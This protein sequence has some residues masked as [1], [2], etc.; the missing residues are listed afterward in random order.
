MNLFGS[1]ALMF[2]TVIAPITSYQLFC[3]QIDKSYLQLH[4][5][6]S[7]KHGNNIIS[8]LDVARVRI[9]GFRW[10][11]PGDF[12]VHK[13]Y[14]LVL[15]FRNRLSI[16]NHQNKILSNFRVG[17]YLGIRLVDLT[18]AKNVNTIQPMLA[19]QYCDGEICWFQRLVEKEL[20]FY[21]SQDAGAQ[22]LSSIINRK[23]WK[24]IR[25]EAQQMGK[26]MAINLV[27]ITVI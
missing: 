24:N 25:G 12:V 21:R 20:W 13:E 15:L 27:K 26:N 23:Q 18:P 2:Y 8:S 3:H 16:I 19:I 17:L 5:H 14:G 22:E 7:L 9:G 1:Y 6:E 10:I 11:S 4:R